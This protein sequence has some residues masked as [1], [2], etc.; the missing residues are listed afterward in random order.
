MRAL[1]VLLL[2]L[3]VSLSV[4]GAE[5]PSDRTVSVAYVFSD[6]NLPGT[7]AAYA[8]LLKEHPELAGRVKISALTESSFNS[9][10][11]AELLSA[12]VLVLDTMN[13]QL[14]SRFNAAYRTDLIRTVSA[15]GKVL[16]VGEGL[17]PEAHYRDLGV[18]WNA[19]AREYWAHSGASNQLGLMK[20]A[21]ADA[22][23]RGLA[24]PAPEGSL[25]FGYYYPGARG[26]PGQV[27]A[28]WAAFDAWRTTHGKKRSSAARVAIS[29]FKA[30]HYTGDSALIDALVAEV[31]KQGAEAIPVFGYP[32]VISVQ[33]LLLDAQG[34][35][36]AD[37]IL[38]SNFNF[39]DADAGKLLARIG[40]P[41]LNLITLYGRSEAEWR[42]SPAGLSFF[43]GTFNLA[44]PELAGTI[45]P[46]VVASKEKNRDAVSGLDRVVTQPIAAQVS[47]AVARGLGWANLHRKANAD[48][49]IALMYYNFPPGKAGIGA[50]YLNVAESITNILSSLARA[51]Y[52][53]GGTPPDAARIL[54]DVT[55]KARNIGGHAP[56]ELDELVRTGSVQRIPVTEYRRWLNAYPAA[57]RSKILKDWGEPERSRLMTTGE[58]SAR[59]FVVPALH[60]GKITLLPQPA[61]GWGEDLEKLYHASDLAPPHQYVATY[62]WLRRGLHADAIIHLGTHGTLEWLDGKDAGLTPEDASDALIA[63]LPNLYVYNVD[64]VGEGLVARRRS[65]AA[66]VD[67]MVPPFRK[68]GL[69]AE[70]AAL[71]ELMS[72]HTRNESKNPELAETLARQVQ[73]Q[74]VKLGIAKD[75]GLSP[76]SAWSDEQLH[77]VENY[78]LDLKGQ[79][80]PWGLHAFGRSPTDEARASTV[81]AIVAV[82]RKL[83]PDQQRVLATDMDQ[84]IRASGPRELESLQLGLAGR[85]LPGGNGGEPLR[86]PD[87]YATGK[88]FYGVDPDKIPKP[89]SWEMG[90]SLA[91]QML[92]EHRK[93]R[94]RYPEK[95]SFV[96]WGDE[97]MRHEGVL[98]SQIFYLLGTRPVWNDRGKLVD[99]EVIPRAQLGRPRVDIVIASAAEG[100][101]SNVTQLMDRAVQRVKLIDE[102][103]NA[104]RR[105]Y[106]ATR[107]ALIAR[108]RKPEDADRLA[109]VRIFDEPP[110]Q[111][112]LNTSGIVANSGS[113]DSDKG[114][115]NDYIRKL[116]H[117]Y[118]NGFWGE[119]ME[120][121]FRL[122]LS[123]TEKVVHSS[124]TTTYGALD[125]D[126]FF[127]YMGGLA[128]AVRS[129]DGASPAM[130]V[131]NTRDP[132]RPEMT[133]LDR[134]IGQ[135]FRSRYTNPA[136]IQG[137][138]KEGY[139]G[140]GEMRAFVEYLWGW[141]ATVPAVVDDAMW[142]QTFEVY[143]KDK[144]NLGMKEFF[145]KNSPYAF[146][147]MTARMLETVRK[148]YWRANEATRASLLREYVAHVAAHGA[149]CTEVSCGNPRLLEYVLE[150]APAAGVPAPL[151]QQARAALEAA[152]K[153]KVEAAAK[154]LAEFART[155]DARENELAGSVPAGEQISGY[156]MEEQ[157]RDSPAPAATSATQDAWWRT[158]LWA[159]PLLAVLA[160]W[161]QRALRRGI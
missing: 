72:D 117:G 48:K 129:I 141:D 51:G 87:A 83:L 124:S 22:G 71:G 127:M 63:D 53:V 23:V 139:A 156:R 3:L 41:A 143:V 81:E 142:Q 80:I 25:D 108:G 78:L 24:L 111:F 130:V 82:D 29:F 161:R 119:P 73:T 59:A 99:V 67:H 133:S 31:E 104:I 38:G 122:A 60:Y 7:A 1:K 58:G 134:F 140:A 146:Q 131:T 132:G 49:R 61:R 147:D 116:G 125:N 27:F 115:A 92:E 66:L 105:H 154:R 57:L 44:V 137:M 90:A 114:F 74:A 109:G 160:I 120:D 40:I 50:S 106:L 121:V 145:E 101:F 93:T 35:P 45:A 16:G 26:E 6:A 28:D 30:A 62:A 128:A 17:L 118:G 8:A 65:M 37:V 98:E 94:G 77:R 85:A 86:N 76:S 79:N 13:E 135:E 68:G 150:Q 158:L 43:E 4:R 102:Q 5:P 10:P 70:F 155:N 56:G 75:L 69:T 34:R 89:A 2:S 152:M 126:D 157:R 123:G 159:L 42:S 32:G 138:Q 113:W 12:D 14:V 9:T 149:N 19:R 39:A 84:R 52:D 46:T 21:L 64:V 153:E 15:R 18:I 11:A 33:R 151:V 95:V 97:T 136:W 103:D 144:L 47:L 55:N 96:I 91:R 36:R 88:N 54:A 110:G 148:G 20:M 112:N 107:S 100:M